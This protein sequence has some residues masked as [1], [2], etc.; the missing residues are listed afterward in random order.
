MS[1]TNEKL[2]G[3]LKVCIAKFLPHCLARKKNIVTT[4]EIICEYV[5]YPIETTTPSLATSGLSHS[6]CSR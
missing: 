3:M 4:S 1:R 5:L 2:H 6:Y